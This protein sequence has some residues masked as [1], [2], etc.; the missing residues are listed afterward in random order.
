V[1]A[2][3]PVLK[4][5]RSVS[6]YITAEDPEKTVTVAE[7]FALVLW[8]QGEG[9][10]QQAKL[11]FLN[12]TASGDDEAAL[13][14]ATL[15]G[16]LGIGI[17]CSQSLPPEVLEHP[18]FAAGTPGPVVHVLAAG[19][20]SCLLFVHEIRFELAP[21]PTAEDPQ[22]GLGAVAMRRRHTPIFGVRKV[23]PVTREL[24]TEGTRAVLGAD[25]QPVLY[26]VVP[27]G[28]EYTVANE[29]G[30]SPKSILKLSEG[31]SLD[32]AIALVEN[33]AR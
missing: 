19:P 33:L 18:I 14:I 7:S 15:D 22:N 24:S 28:V 13:R 6:S 4:L 23:L 27:E 31:V 1:H 30:W 8:W 21:S 20:N 32:Q 9:D 16:Q 25:L 2:R 17:G 10:E 3:N 11:A 29:Q 12:L 26:R 5:A